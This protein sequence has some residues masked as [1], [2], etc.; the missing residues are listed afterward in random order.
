[1]PAVCAFFVKGVLRMTQMRYV[2]QEVFQIQE[3][4]LRQQRLQ[5]LVESY[6]REVKEQFL[7]QVACGWPQDC[8]Q[9]NGL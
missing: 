2:V 5:S 1:M 3:T 4:E 7:Q 6:R 8:L 9:G